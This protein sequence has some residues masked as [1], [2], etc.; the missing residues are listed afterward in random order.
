MAG[1]LRF[2]LSRMVSRLM[3]TEGP[4]VPEPP[5]SSGLPPPPL[6]PPAH[7]PAPPM[8]APL[9]PAGNRGHAGSAPGP[10]LPPPP[11]V[12]A[13]DA[14]GVDEAYYD[15]L[16]D[17]VNDDD[18]DDDDDNYDD[19]DDDDDDD[20][21]EEE[22]L[23]RRRATGRSDDGLFGNVLSELI[24]ARVPGRRQSGRSR[25]GRTL[26][27]TPGEP[28]RLSSSSMAAAA[29]ARAAGPVRGG[30]NGSPR[31][32]AHDGSLTTPSGSPRSKRAS[33]A[34]D[35]SLTEGIS[36]NDDETAEDFSDDEYSTMLAYG[37][38]QS[39]NASKDS[40]RY[41]ANTLLH[42]SLS[43]DDPTL[44][45]PLPP[46]AAAP[47]NLSTRSP[48]PPPAGSL[49]TPASRQ[50]YRAQRASTSGTFGLLSERP[51]K[52]A[53]PPPRP[54]SM[55]SS[56]ASS[57][58]VSPSSGSFP[59]PPPALSTRP[60]PVGPRVSSQRSSTITALSRSAPP[61]PRS[62]PSSMPLKARIA[63][64]SS[65]LGKRMS[66][67]VDSFRTSTPPPP[68]LLLAP[69]PLV[70]RLAPDTRTALESARSRGK[71]SSS[72]SG[73]APGGSQSPR[74]K[75]F[76]RDLSTRTP[77]PPPAPAPATASPPRT[78]PRVSVPGA[79]AQAKKTKMNLARD[80]NLLGA[81]RGIFEPEPVA[82]EY[83]DRADLR[84]MTADEHIAAF[85]EGSTEIREI[86]AAS[87]AALVEQA[88]HKRSNTKLQ[89]QLLLS[90]PGYTTAHDLL[91]A[92]IDRYCMEVPLGREKEVIPVRV[93]AFHMLK[94]WLAERPFDY[95][96]DPK[97]AD[98]LR[99]FFDGTLPSMG[100]A[101]T[102]Q[103]LKR[104]LA[105]TLE[106]YCGDG[107]SLKASDILSAH[108]M[109]KA[110][111]AATMGLAWTDISDKILSEQVTLYDVELF[112]KIGVRELFNKAWSDKHRK[113]ERAP[114]V[115]AVISWFNHFSSWIITQIVSETSFKARV[116]LVA[117]F[118]TL[119]NHFRVLNNLSGVMA[120][121]AALKT[122][123]VKRLAKTWE[124]MSSADMLRFE[125][126]TDIVSM[127][128]NYANM[129]RI[130]NSTPDDGFC[131]PYLGMYLSDLTFMED[132][133]VDTVD[134][135]LI[136]FR[137]WRGVASI[138]GIIQRHQ[139][140][141]FNKPVHTAV[142]AYIKT[143]TIFDDERAYEESLLREP[144]KKKRKKATKK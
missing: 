94:L 99:A 38:F 109:I 63:P 77:P 110:P 45:P 23:R 91:A 62:R 26:P 3:R 14:T 18:D 43:I 69:L 92:I 76:S 103:V 35:D 118:I 97:L 132:G 121:V 68:A 31:R 34:A 75:R 98:A 80:I 89:M 50:A 7:S 1:F 32:L 6:P 67:P 37:H 42:S 78:K 101:R 105:K 70:P 141:Q 28:S 96:E 61:L 57:P 29:A 134:D 129:R 82:E 95:T 12:L 108:A 79:D 20:V 27:S 136:N 10:A 102:G 21:D 83:V 51:K 122:A 119:G 65:S 143:A 56:P 93:Q 113:H 30:G 144:R 90:Y 58:P 114:N 47:S 74:G 59:A 124:K 55:P 40:F 137:K 116:K 142:R 22:E 17:D 112:K 52:P 73:T 13:L 117:R 2:L 54:P 11:P 87:L 72:R 64:P 66:A 85:G 130:A 138:I 128:K 111:A 81:A 104:C 140:M 8:P 24:K 127:K 25:S 107:Q 133:N 123:E 36:S 60:P 100:L 106:T 16:E 53:R 9:H 41:V 84:W 39:A 86:D 15:N 46:P 5:T 49:A 44:P 48:P 115:L 4:P 135:G 126:L 139:K 33:L 131:L 88:T 19:D 125:A 71:P 120:V